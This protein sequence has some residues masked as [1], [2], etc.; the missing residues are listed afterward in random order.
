MKKMRS[1][2]LDRAEARA[3]AITSIADPLELGGELTLA[4]YRAV[5][6]DARTKLGTYNT[7]LSGTDEARSRFLVAERKL[8]DWSDRMLA[9]VGAVYGRNSDAYEKAGGKRKDARRP[10]QTDTAS[11]EN[12]PDETPAA[13]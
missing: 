5:I 10:S 3:A 11:E 4:A 2:D 8:A 7:L 12:T 1:V 13:A 6:S 9:A